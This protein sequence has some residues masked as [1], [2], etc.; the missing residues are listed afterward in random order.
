MKTFFCIDIITDGEHINTQL[1]S[2]KV[3]KIGVNGIYGR[4]APKAPI[5][6]GGYEFYLELL[7]TYNVE[8]CGVVGKPEKQRRYTLHFVKWQPY[9]RDT[10]QMLHKVHKDVAR[11]MVSIREEDLVEDGVVIL[12]D[13]R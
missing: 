9:K 11:V 2:T 5:L 7:L 4:Y 1:Q 12:R 8:M 10:N 3:Y 13:Q 6:C